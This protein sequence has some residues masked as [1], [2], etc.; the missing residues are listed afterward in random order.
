[1]NNVWYDS[2]WFAAVI[3]SLLTLTIF[4]FGQYIARKNQEKT[5]KKNM[6]T[7]ITQSNATLFTLI[8]RGSINI[9]SINYI[10]LREELDK[11]NIIYIL[12]SN[13]KSIFIELYTIHYSGPEFY[14]KNKN[15]IHGHLKKVVE[16]L[17]KYG[18]ESFGD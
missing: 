18:V 6:I 10:K 4:I 15:K 5:D 9:N 1:M 14:D 7:L 12:P 3:S 17:N 8:F 16:I 2:N 13:L 11:T